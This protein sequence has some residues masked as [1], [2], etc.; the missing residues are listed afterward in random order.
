VPVTA[1]LLVEQLDGAGRLDVDKLVQRAIEMGRAEGV[2]WQ[3]E[4]QLVYPHP[5]QTPPPGL[6]GNA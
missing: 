6:T 2:A 1:D 3:P 4:E 5:T